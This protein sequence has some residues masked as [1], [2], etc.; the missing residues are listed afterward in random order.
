MGMSKSSSGVRRVLFK[1]GS[2]TTRASYRVLY[3]IS[4]VFFESFCGRI[5]GKG[6]SYGRVKAGLYVEGVLIQ[7]V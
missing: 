7:V 5:E 4:D 1:E 3:E 2:V 6:L